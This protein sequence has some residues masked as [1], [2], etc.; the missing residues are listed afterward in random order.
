[1]Y[2]SL[3]IEFITFHNRIS[4]FICQ[5]Q[6]NPL[7]LV[8]LWNR[9]WVFHFNDQITVNERKS[10]IG[11][12]DSNTSVIK[13]VIKLVIEKKKSW[14]FRINL[15]FPSQ[16]FSNFDTSPLSNS[17]FRSLE[18]F[19][20]KVQNPFFH[21]ENNISIIKNSPITNAK[22]MERTKIFHF[23]RRPEISPKAIH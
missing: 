4:S 1:M 10:V 9:K 2:L 20:S 11:R 3:P 13:I 8:F 18:F 5:I 15:N 21:R 7:S 12:R 22:K 16:N 19:F 23:Q 17:N 6:K 14:N